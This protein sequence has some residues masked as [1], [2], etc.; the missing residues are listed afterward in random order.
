MSNENTTEGNTAAKN[1]ESTTVN[2][3]ISSAYTTILSIFSI[4]AANTSNSGIAMACGV[5]AAC[6]IGIGVYNYAKLRTAFNDD[7]VEKLTKAGIGQASDQA[8][9]TPIPTEI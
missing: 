7:L 6:S 9:A 2:L 8:P 1:I 4:V 3:A 5:G